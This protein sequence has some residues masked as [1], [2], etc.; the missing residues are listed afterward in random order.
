MALESPL[1]RSV[2]ERN[3]GEKHGEHAFDG[4]PTS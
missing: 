1:P 2:F 4:D 3:M